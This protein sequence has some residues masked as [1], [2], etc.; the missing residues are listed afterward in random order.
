LFE[1]IPLSDKINSPSHN[2]IKEDALNALI[3]LG[4]SKNNIE[5][6]MLKIEQQ[7]PLDT[8]KVEDLIKLVLKNL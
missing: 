5:Q 7:Q 4:I 3:G 1:D 2:T 8:L 6:A